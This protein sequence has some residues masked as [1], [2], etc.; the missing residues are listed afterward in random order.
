MGTLGDTLRGERLRRGLKQEEIAAEIKISPFMVE[1][2]E[3]GR[4]D[5]LPGG[6][7][8]RSFLRQYA[9]L[10]GV[11]EEEIVAEFRQEYGEPEVA[12]PKPPK[13]KQRRVPAGVLWLAVAGM[14]CVGVYKFLPNVRLDLPEPANRRPSI[15]IAQA[16]QAGFTPPEEKQPPKLEAEPK[17]EEAVAPVR[18]VLSA[19]QPVWV[20][21]QCDGLSAF[22]GMIE[23][24][25]AK[26]FSAT[27]KVTVLVGNAG[28]L[29]ISLNGH[30][31]HPLGTR[32]EI[33]LVEL[34][35]QGAR[36]VPR[37]RVQSPPPAPE[38]EPGGAI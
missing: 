16:T 8:R 27:G 13:F 25:A 11:D 37:R 21:V 17:P 31:V 14:A 26:E 22:R 38:D 34:T 10:L 5:R 12:L 9:H 6:S 7:Y 28:G 3:A 29:A 2:M 24:S 20:S 35:P 4:F 32:R 1:A 18:V 30:A 36:V 33:Q 15:A 23:A 19:S